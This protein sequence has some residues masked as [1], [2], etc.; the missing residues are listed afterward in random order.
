VVVGLQP[1]PLALPLVVTRQMP[2]AELQS[3]HLARCEQVTRNAELHAQ[4][5][6]AIRCSGVV[7]EDDGR[8]HHQRY[9]ASDDD[10]V[11]LGLSDLLLTHEAHT[12]LLTPSPPCS[13]WLSD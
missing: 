4:E 13:S 3:L 1:S 8:G 11:L 7:D 10:I 5:A 2:L 12:S 9:L 6:Q